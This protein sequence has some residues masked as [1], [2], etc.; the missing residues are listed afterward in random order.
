MGLSTRL[1]ICSLLAIIWEKYWKM[2]PTDLALLMRLQG[3]IAIQNSKP[4]PIV[5]HC[6]KLLK[7]V[8]FCM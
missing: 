6:H 2:F 8:G 5:L 7:D 1:Q 3:L 4:W